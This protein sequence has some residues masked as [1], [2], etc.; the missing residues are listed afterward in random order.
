MNPSEPILPETQEYATSLAAPPSGLF[1][2]EAIL[3]NMFRIQ[4]C[5]RGDRCTGMTLTLADDRVEVL[6]QWFECIGRHELLFDSTI[7]GIFKGLRFEL[8]GSPYSTVVRKVTLLTTEMS[9]NYAEDLVQDAKYHVSIVSLIVWIFNF[10]AFR[11]L[12]YGYTQHC[13]TRLLSGGNDVVLM[14]PGFRPLV[15]KIIVAALRTYLCRLVIFCC[16]L[17]PILLSRRYL[18]AIFCFECVFR[19]AKFMLDPFESNG[20]ITLLI[21]F[22]LFITIILLLLHCLPLPLI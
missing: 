20:F 21:L 11:I 8:C 18:V 3:K 16:L 4:T 1:A 19:R 7:D 5:Y 15:R 9:I 12:S 13:Q 22:I 2:S 14:L 6:G 10:D 17:L